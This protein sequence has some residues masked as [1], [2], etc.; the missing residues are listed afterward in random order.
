[1]RV[2]SSVAA[3]LPTIAPG[4]S[5]LDRRWEGI[6]DQRHGDDR[7]RQQA[8]R[9]G[10]GE[11]EPVVFTHDAQLQVCS[12]VMAPAEADTHPP[13][14]VMLIAVKQPG[15]SKP[16]AVLLHHKQAMTTSTLE[17]HHKSIFAENVYHLSAFNFFQR[18]SV[19]SVSAPI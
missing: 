2:H 5:H 3:H 15:A 4:L 8:D 16:R 10:H 13:F 19:S 12:S 1:M 6:R 14:G 18:E 7:S 17:R 9:C 11:L